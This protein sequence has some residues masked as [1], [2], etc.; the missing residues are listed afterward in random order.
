MLVL[1]A[2]LGTYWPDHMYRN[3]TTLLTICFCCGCMAPMPIPSPPQ[4]LPQKTVEIGSYTVAVEAETSLLTTIHKFVGDSNEITIQKPLHFEHDGTTIDLSSGTSFS[5]AF[6]DDSGQLVFNR[7]RP[8]VTTSLF[9]PFKIHPVLDRILFKSPG[10]ATAVVIDAFGVEHQKTIDLGRSS[11][12]SGCPPNDSMPSPEPCI[13]PVPRRCVSRPTVYIWTQRYGKSPEHGHGSLGTA[14]LDSLSGFDCPF[15]L[16]VNPNDKVPYCDERPCF[17][18]STEEGP[19]RQVGWPGKDEFLRR[20]AEPDNYLQPLPPSKASTPPKVVHPSTVASQ[21][22]RSAPAC[23]HYHRC[24]HAGTK[25]SSSP[26]S[27][28]MHTESSRGNRHDH[29]CPVCGSVQWDIYK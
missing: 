9:G 14:A 18:W 13:S 19:R 10:T 17:E 5:Y 27:V 6:A 29:T 3:S 12:P 25:H 28:W 1:K 7:P 11:V 2:I 24:T 23:Y 4:R 16:I 8:V 15:D 21:V 26:A 20:W 22:V